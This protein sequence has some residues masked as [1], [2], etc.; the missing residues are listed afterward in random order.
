[1]EDA[2]IFY[3]HLVHFT[4]FC[5]VLWIFG[6]VCRN[7]VYFS[8]F[9]ILFEEKSGNPGFCCAK[10]INHFHFGGEGLMRAFYGLASVVKRL[11]S[12]ES[13]K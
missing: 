11:D 6:T 2:G 12:V 4:V 3:R 8:R 5:Y 13:M 10:A 7:L 9:G 1:M